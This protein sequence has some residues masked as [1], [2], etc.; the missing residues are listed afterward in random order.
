MRKTVGLLIVAICIF[1]IWYAVAHFRIGSI[2]CVS[3]F[4]KC[5]NNILSIIDKVEKGNVLVTRK[6]L[7]KAISNNPYIKKYSIQLKLNGRYIVF[8]EERIPK[9]CIRGTDKN[10]FSD[11]EGLIIKIE[12][13]GEGTCVKETGVDYQLGNRLSERDFFIQ[14]IFYKIRNIIGIGEAR[15]N[16][17]NLTVEYK[18]KI[19]LIFPTE[20]D[21]VSL[22]GKAYY[23][24]SQFDK[25]EEYIIGVGNISISEVDFRFNDP[26]VRFI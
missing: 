25:I 14:D 11:S 15:V 19:K 20:G 9:Y 24:V 17:N 22:A 16:E 4:T 10:Y 8:I 5:N 26:I 6:R 2:E 13:G 21:A 7:I 23:T 18:G 1:A 3:Q 12:E